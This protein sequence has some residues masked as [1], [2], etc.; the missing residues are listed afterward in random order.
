MNI[1][2]NGFGRIGKTIFLQ[3]LDNKLINVKAI[4]IP[5]FD[6]NNLES[7]LKNDSVHHYHKD[8]HVEILSESCFKINNQKIYLFNNRDPS[9]L[10]WQLH[11]I[12]YVIDSTVAFLTVDKASKHN[13]NYVIMCAPPKD[14]TP[15]F[16]YNVNHDNYKGEPII[17]NASC[18]TNCITPV[19]KCLM[20]SN[21]I[22][23]ANFTTIHATTA[24]QNVSDT[25][26]FKNRTRRSILNNI[27]PHSTGASK[28]IA[29]VLP[30]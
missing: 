26:K 1:G 13:C 3:L 10:N 2:I 16:I 15:Q 4:N 5:D 29:K 24:S 20:E 27:I 22:I 7:Y 25:I 14:N 21:E 30:K 8:F 17:S 12:D 18:T 19:L 28:S 6:I 23:S 11:N 9:L